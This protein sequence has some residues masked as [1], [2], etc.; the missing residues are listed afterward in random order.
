[1]KKTIETTIQTTFGRCGC[2]N[3]KMTKL[4]EEARSA[5]YEKTT[6][7]RLAMQPAKRPQAFQADVTSRA[8]RWAL[9]ALTSAL[10]NNNA[11]TGTAAFTATL[12]SHL[13]I[14]SIA[15]VLAAVDEAPQLSTPKMLSSFVQKAFALQ[16]LSGKTEQR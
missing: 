10:T 13:A 4:N 2:Q 6:L 7:K 14:R 8:A 5:F 9:Q 3:G 15:H 1:M 11:D 12:P 16:L